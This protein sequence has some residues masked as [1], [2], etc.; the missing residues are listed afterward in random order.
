MLGASDEDLPAQVECGFEDPRATHHV[1]T[2][3]Y[4]P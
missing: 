4:P 2:V 3:G 1:F